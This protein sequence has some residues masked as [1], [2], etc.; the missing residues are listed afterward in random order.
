MDIAVLQQSFSKHD[1]RAIIKFYVLQHQSA[2][3]IHKIMTSALGSHSPSYNTI[4]EWVSAFKNGKT[5]TDDEHRSG[6]PVSVSTTENVEKVKALLEEDRRITLRQIA[7]SLNISKDTAHHILTVELGKRKIAAKWIP[8]VLTDEQRVCRAETCG[9]H[10]RKYRREGRKFL[11]RIVACDETWAYSW[12]PELKRQ[13][14]EWR[15]PDSPRPTK[16][17]RK[18]GQLKVMHLT[19]FDVEGI[20]FDQAV[21][22]GQTVNAAYYLDILRTKIRRAVRDKRPNLHENKVILLQDNAAPHRAKVVLEA[23]EEWGW[24]TLSH[25]PYSPDLSPCDYFLFPKVKESLRGRRFDDAESIN[26]AFS[27]SLRS[28]TKTDFQGGIERLPHRWQKCVDT[29]GHYME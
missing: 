21:P 24:K 3:D 7:Y 2:T 16:A 8:H 17:I 5:G 6:R 10:L 15:A 25:P 28:L 9:M 11:Q 22:I 20:I 12:Q 23:L 13:S 26:A 27:T 18:Q 1:I 29:D 19:F 4:R 14:S